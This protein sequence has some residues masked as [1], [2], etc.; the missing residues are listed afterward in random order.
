MAIQ[1][2]EWL[3]LL[4]L[5]WQSSRWFSQLYRLLPLMNLVMVLMILR[6]LSV[7]LMFG[8]PLGKLYSGRLKASSWQIVCLRLWPHLRVINGT[9][10]PL[11]LFQITVLPF[12]SIYQLLLLIDVRFSA[13]Q[14]LSVWQIPKNKGLRVKVIY[15]LSHPLPF[16]IIWYCWFS[17]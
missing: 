13:F 5:S 10:P 1:N 7:S 4:Q 15:D 6:W 17:K 12:H 9:S 8:L 16:T 11:T 2:Q 3:W 14:S